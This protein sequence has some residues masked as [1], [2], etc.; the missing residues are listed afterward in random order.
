MS[1]LDALRRAYAGRAPG[2]LGARY[3]CAVLCPLAQ[4]PE[5]LSLLFEVRADSLRRQPGEVCF[6]GGHAEPG[7]TA[8]QCA[9]RETWEELGIPASAV[10][11]SAP[12]DFLVQQGK[13]VMEPILAAVDA[14]AAETLRLNRSEVKET[15]LAPV[16]FFLAN[17]PAVYTYDLLPDVPE[18]F[19]YELIGFPQGYPWRK[20]RASVPIYR[21]QGHV[22]WGLTGRIVRHLLEEME[23]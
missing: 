4:T 14:A 21:W 23:G 11:P 20:G 19:P 8:R 15:F 1:A 10:T 2:L 17:P 6:P 22:I 13:F 7:E 3:S 18:D 12:L 16:E 5:G 9:L